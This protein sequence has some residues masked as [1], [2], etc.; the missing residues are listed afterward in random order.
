MTRKKKSW[1]HKQNFARTTTPQEISD[2]LH[3]F[4]QNGGGKKGRENERGEC[5]EMEGKRKFS[6]FMS[7]G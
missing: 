6:S 4:W 5:E 2:K 1:K 7:F 3:Y